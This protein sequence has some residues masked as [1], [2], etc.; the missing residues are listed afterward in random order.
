[1][2]LSKESKIVTALDYASGTASR[3]GAACDMQGF[4][5]VA[6]I[7]KFATIA[8]GATTS[9]KAQQSSDNGSADAYS[10]LEGTGQTV[11]ADDDNQVFVIDLVRPT[12]RYVRLVVT[13]DGA[14][15]AAESA[16]YL[17]Y[18]AKD[19]PVTMNVTDEV[20]AETHVSPAEGTA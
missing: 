17:L 15:A 5:A 18:G 14:N 11:A 20:T 16:I 2:N 9:I 19:L 3:N 1:M 8:V 13:K 6:M 7:V 12:K 4:E 10:D